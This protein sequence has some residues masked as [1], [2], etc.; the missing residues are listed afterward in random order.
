[1]FEF[2]SID[3]QVVKNYFGKLCRVVRYVMF[4]KTFHIVSRGVL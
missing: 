2:Y 4:Y 1:M 3:N